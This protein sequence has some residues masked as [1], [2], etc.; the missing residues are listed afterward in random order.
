MA[1]CPLIHFVYFF[2]VAQLWH[3]LRQLLH[4]NIRED[5]GLHED[6]WSHDDHEYNRMCA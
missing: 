3:G 5:S 6:A 4:D 2:C 1:K